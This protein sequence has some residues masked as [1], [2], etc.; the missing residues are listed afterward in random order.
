MGEAVV[1]SIR[2]SFLDRRL[3]DFCQEETNRERFQSLVSNSGAEPP[4]SREQRMKEVA[5]E[6]ES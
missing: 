2:C 4:D 5:R 6:S 3:F 1:N